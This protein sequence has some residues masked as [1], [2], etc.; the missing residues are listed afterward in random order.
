M[1]QSR[2]LSVLEAI[3]NVIIGGVAA[4]FAQ[5]LLFPV[6]GLQVSLAQTLALNA[7]FTAVSFVRCYILRRLFERVA[8]DERIGNAPGS[9]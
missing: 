4:L 7:V 3:T 1:S 2:S 6:M 8:S 9:H 5:L